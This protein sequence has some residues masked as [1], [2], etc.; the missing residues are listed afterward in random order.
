M[1]Q[2]AEAITSVSYF[3]ITYDL[4]D[5]DVVVSRQSDDL[6][7]RLDEVVQLEENASARMRDSRTVLEPEIEEVAYYVESRG[8]LTNA[9]DELNEVVLTCS[10]GLVGMGDEVD[11]GDKVDAGPGAV[12]MRCH[13]F[14]SVL[15]RC[16]RLVRR[17][18]SGDS[19]AN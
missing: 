9:A 16:I 11:I 1:N 6:Y 12:R 8:V 7:S 4:T 17:G 3:G 5:P 2:T 15:S 19:R 13:Q 18:S 10:L 14:C